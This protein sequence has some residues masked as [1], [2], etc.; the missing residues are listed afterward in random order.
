MYFFLIV[1]N[2]FALMMERG[3]VYPTI[4][5]LFFRHTLNPFFNRLNIPRSYKYFGAMALWLKMI[6]DWWVQGG[7]K[8]GVK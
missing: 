6:F 2:F 4:V 8:R 5:R 3:V 7:G 1:C